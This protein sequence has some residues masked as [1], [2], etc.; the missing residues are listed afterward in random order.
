MRWPYLLPVVSA[1]RTSQCIGVPKGPG[2]SGWYQIL[3]RF[4]DL[5]AEAQLLFEEDLARIRALES[6]LASHLQFVTM[7]V[8]L[9]AGLVGWAF[10][11]RAIVS[12]VCSLVGTGYLVMAGFGSQLGIR[13]VELNVATPLDVEWAAENER[14]PVVFLAAARMDAVQRNSQLSVGLH[15]YIWGVEWSLAWAAIFLG[16]SAMAVVFKIA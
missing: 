1:W 12:V 2:R 16:L 3:E 7:L 8:P 14:D 13:S 11:N 10:A 5:R 15:N 4:P 9:S 6:K